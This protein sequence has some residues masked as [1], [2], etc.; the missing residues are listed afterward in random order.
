MLSAAEPL[1]NPSEFRLRGSLFGKAR[2][3]SSVKA[4]NQKKRAPWFS[5]AWP[6]VAFQADRAKIKKYQ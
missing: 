1:G 3:K 5:P 6:V 4:T 2:Q